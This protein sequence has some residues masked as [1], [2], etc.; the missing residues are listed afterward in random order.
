MH[1]FLSPRTHV[2]VG[3]LG[4]HIF[5]SENCILFTPVSGS[6]CQWWILNIIGWYGP[7][8][9]TWTCKRIGS[10]FLHECWFSLVTKEVIRAYNSPE[11]SHWDWSWEDPFRGPFYLG[12]PPV[13][14][15]LNRHFNDEQTSIF[16]WMILSLTSFSFP[17]FFSSLSPQCRR[18]LSFF[19]WQGS[20]SWRAT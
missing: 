16:L 17:L 11:Y 2:R 15:V 4:T 13:A 7:F 19:P 6:P 10:G 9:S 8:Y 3:A 20:F 1:S 12:S 14:E 5:L 18:H